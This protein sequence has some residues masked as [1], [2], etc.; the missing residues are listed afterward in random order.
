[1]TR[2]YQ[3]KLHSDQLAELS[4]MGLRG[5]SKALV[6]LRN[7]VLTYAK[8]KAPTL[9]QGDTGTGKEL[10]ARAI[11]YVGVGANAPFVIINCAAIPESLFEKEFFGAERGAYTDARSRQIGLLEQANG[12]TLFLDEINSVKPSCQA[13][14]LRYLECGTFRRVGGQSEIS[15][16]SKVVAAANQDLK[17]LAQRGSFRK[18]LLY[19]I[20]V[21]KINVPLL[22][23]RQD[24]IVLIARSIVNELNES[25]SQE[26]TLSDAA[27]LWLQ[28]RQW[29]GNIRELKNIIHRLYLSATDGL[30]EPPNVSATLKQNSAQPNSFKAEKQKVVDRF[31]LDYLTNLLTKTNGNVSIAA[32]I[33]GKERRCFSRLMKKHNLARQDFLPSGSV[34]TQTTVSG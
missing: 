24:D 32:R 17:L 18:D 27:E 30:L 15:T 11:H 25:Y 28:N 21:I 20:N 33:A 31:E 3:T 5:Q 10:V 26:N 7:Q 1:M 22:S 8:A 13:I 16:S 9:I 34:N 14:L 4:A 12:G 2:N 19:R 29:P 23:E 6:R